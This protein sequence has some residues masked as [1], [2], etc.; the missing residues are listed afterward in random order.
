[1][2]ERQ[3]DGLELLLGT[4]GEVGHGAMFDF[5]LYAEGLAEQDAVISFAVSG[6][7]GPVEI[8]SE[9]NNGIQ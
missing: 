2:L 1:M 7:L 9:H 8:H 6:G 3:S 4:G 5:A